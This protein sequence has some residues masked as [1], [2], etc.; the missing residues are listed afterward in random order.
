M[1]IYAIDIARLLLPDLVVFVTSLVTLGVAV[2]VCTIH[3]QSVSNSSPAQT[4]PSGR[5]SLDAEH[6]DT[7]AAAVPAASSSSPTETTNLSVTPGHLPPSNMLFGVQ[8]YLMFPGWTVPLFDVAVFALMWL[9]GVA[10]PS[11]TSF[12]YFA[13]FLVLMLSWSLHLTSMGVSRFLRMVA[14]VYCTA[15]FLLL[16][17][18]QF[19]D[20]QEE[21][22]TQPY[23]T[24]DSLMAR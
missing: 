17:L 24:I 14:L 16:Y 21:V 3:R 9:G 13:V 1:Y 20:F 11:V 10:L 15:H 22:A 6:G 12:F 2:K 23:D 18:Y 5:E 4:P 8:G 19:Q 7:G